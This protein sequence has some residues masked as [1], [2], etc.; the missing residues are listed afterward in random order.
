MSDILEDLF[1]YVRFA[2]VSADPQYKDQVQGCAD[3]LVQRFERAGL[4]V[5]K[6]PTAGHPIVVAKSAPHPGR[7][8]VLIY[9]H[10]DVQ[11]QI[12]SNSGAL[13]HLSRS[14]GMAG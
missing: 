14:S 5:K 7:K 1:S 13:R 10:Y 12:R 8:T 9:G 3:W 6:H 4:E 2:S 11:P